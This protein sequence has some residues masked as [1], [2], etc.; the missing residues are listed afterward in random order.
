MQCVS[1]HVRFGRIWS[2]LS[3]GVISHLTFC[4]CLLR[5]LEVWQQAQSP[6]LSFQGAGPTRNDDS[7]DFMPMALL[8]FTLLIV[9]MLWSFV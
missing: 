9:A 5:Q 2:A 4:Q 8:V 1:G 7:A 3:V 6:F